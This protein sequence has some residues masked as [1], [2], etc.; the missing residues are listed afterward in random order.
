MKV[1]VE[2]SDEDVKVLK[3][4]LKVDDVGELLKSFLHQ[5]C[6][7]IAEGITMEKAG[8]KITHEDLMQIGREIAKKA[9][10]DS[11]SSGEKK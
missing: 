2:V 7:A 4:I 11:R 1:E 3:G 6:Q 10:E 5:M 9:M 8:I